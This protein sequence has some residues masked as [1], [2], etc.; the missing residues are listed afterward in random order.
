MKNILA[1]VDFSDVSDKVVAQAATLAGAFE[2]SVYLLHIAEPDPDF[3]GYDAGPQVARDAVAERFRD[4]HRQLQELADKLRSDGI[5]AHALLIQ[6][7]FIEKIVS[8]AERLGSDLIITGA[9]NKGLV[10]RVLLGSVSEGLL[11][12]ARIPVLVVPATES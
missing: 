11:R 10:S 4:S 6:G 3:V 2:A 9:H 7:P 5:D 8:E 1:A 12:E